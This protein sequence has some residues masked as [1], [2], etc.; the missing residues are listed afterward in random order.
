[1]LSCRLRSIEGVFLVKQFL[2]KVKIAR[3]FGFYYS[4]CHGVCS[5]STTWL[6]IS[7][8]QKQHGLFSFF[9]MVIYR[10]KVDSN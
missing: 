6:I 3:K 8:L 9:F 4:E 5:L 10:T 2:F 1:M 7:P